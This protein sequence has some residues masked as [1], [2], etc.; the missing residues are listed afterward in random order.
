MI[1]LIKRLNLISV[2]LIVLLVLLI[3][4]AFLNWKI[5]LKRNSLKK[6]LQSLNQKVQSLEERSD[7]LKKQM[8]QKDLLAYLER[9][10]REDLGLRKEG[11]RVAA[12]PIEAIDATN[13]N[14]NNINN[15]KVFKK[16]SL[17]EIIFGH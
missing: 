16:Q 17:W 10:A 7:S 6:E 5:S 8:S 11:E 15:D 3:A 13:T 1:R 9:L 14:I 2:T 4:L 12:F